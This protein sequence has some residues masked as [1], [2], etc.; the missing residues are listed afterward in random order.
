MDKGAFDATNIEMMR[1]DDV[2]FA[3]KIV[4]FLE[5]LTFYDLL[6]ISK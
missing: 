1:C 3:F 6:T 2:I 4:D 5:N